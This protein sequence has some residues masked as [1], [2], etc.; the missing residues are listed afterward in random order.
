M[1]EILKLDNISISYNSKEVVRNVSFELH[2]GEIL[3]IAG[4]SGSG[5]STILKGIQHLLGKNGKITSGRIF[6]EGKDLSKIDRESRRQ[7]AGKFFATIFQNATASFCPIRTIG[8]Q[9]FESVRAHENWSR[10]K[11]TIEARK[12]LSKLDLNES[13]LDQYPF[14]LSGGMSQRA[15]ILAAMILS[16]KILLADEP[17]SALDAVTQVSVVNELL[18]LRKEN[19]MSIILVTHHLG[20]A[21]RMADRI[22]IMRHGSPVEY[23]TRDE[24]FNAPKEIYTRE[25]IQ[26]VPRLENYRVA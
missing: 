22:L 23:G 18:R 4:E 10:D 21:Y 25:L 13:V 9:I 6:Y 7:L 20:V 12:I 16:P 24:I 5:K 14:K 19:G 17:T 26:A 1:N 15:G 11:F 3:V 2:R 8:D